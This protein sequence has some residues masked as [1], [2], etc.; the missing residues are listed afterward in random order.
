MDPITIN[1]NT[2]DLSK[3]DQREFPRDA[4]GT[5]FILLLCNARLKTEEFAKL[6]QLHVE[7]QS[8]VEDTAGQTS[9]LCKYEPEDLDVL[10]RLSFIKQAVVYHP[11]FVTNAALKSMSSEGAGSTDPINVTIQLHDGTKETGEDLLKAIEGFT[12][13]VKLDASESQ[14]R[15]AIPPTALD[16][17]A[18]LDYVKVIEQTKIIQ[19]RDVP[20]FEILRAGRAVGPP[21]H[22]AVYEGEGQ[23]IGIADH[24]FDTGVANDVHPAFK[25]RVLAVLN[26]RTDGINDLTDGAGHGTHVAGC[27]LG[28][29]TVTNNNWMGQ[30]KPDPNHMYT[31]RAP[32]AQARLVFQAISPGDGIAPNFDTLFT[33]T[34]GAPPRVAPIHSNSWGTRSFKPRIQE[35]YTAAESAKID[36]AMNL[37]P[38]LLVVWSAGNDGDMLSRLVPSPPGQP[39]TPTEY[40]RQIGAEAAAKN[41]LTV[42][43]TFNSRLMEARGGPAGHPSETMC[44]D[45]DSE[46][47]QAAGLNGVASELAPFSSRGPTREMRLKPD[48]VAPGVGILSARSRLKHVGSTGNNGCGVCMV[49]QFMFLNGTSQAAPQVAGCAAAVREALVKNG[50]P[51]PSGALVKALLINGAVD[52][53]GTT[54]RAPSRQGNGF[55][56]VN[57]PPAPNSAQGFGRVDLERSLQ[58]VLAAQRAE[59]L[60]LD[61]HGLAQG[62]TEVIE[63][64]IPNNKPNLRVT[65]AYSDREGAV[66]QDILDLSAVLLDGQ[67]QA[68]GAPRLPDPITYLSYQ[69]DPALPPPAHPHAE[70]EPANCVYTH[71]N[72]QKITWLNINQ[73][74]GKVQLTVAA[75]AVSPDPGRRAFSICAYFS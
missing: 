1:G 51:N 16:R 18:Q 7:L 34:Y 53:A 44:V 41:C 64:P 22:Q 28:A 40:Q 32:G 25:D 21:A 71:N 6:Q 59:G 35:P 24:G 26:A 70:L 15:V 68:V 13:A 11:E 17:I 57:M 4:S 38:E 61:S 43:A 50:F 10:N 27:A 47:E 30:P 3:T 62:E 48:V 49:D 37:N 20:A 63:L 72:V 45:G 65:M 69:R 54:W 74:Q 39:P 46:A 23:V 52:L 9:Y 5:N 8:V 58:N 55:V 60:T 66:I 42:G 67:D 31:I 12:T 56:V 14:L 75:R 19:P 33:A 29:L 36:R 2:I 73:P